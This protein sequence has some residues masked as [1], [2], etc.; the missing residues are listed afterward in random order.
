MHKNTIGT[1]K[2]IQGDDVKCCTLPW[3]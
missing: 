1:G 3:R 2:R